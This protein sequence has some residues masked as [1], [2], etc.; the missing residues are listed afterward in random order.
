MQSIDRENHK[1]QNEED[2]QESMATQQKEIKL[3]LKHGTP[4]WEHSM[5]LLTHEN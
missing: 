4:Y 5:F 2:V 3:V 1:T